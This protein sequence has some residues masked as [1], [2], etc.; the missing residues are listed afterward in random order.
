[1]RVVVNTDVP[2]ATATAS[3]LAM[4]IVPVTVDPWDDT[5][6]LI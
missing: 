5:T 3:T 1:M 4:G 6:T 2:A